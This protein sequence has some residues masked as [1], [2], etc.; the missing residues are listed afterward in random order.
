MPETTATSTD[1]CAADEGALEPFCTACGARASIFT[2]RGGKW[3]HYRG[4][5]DDLNVE[6]YDPGH[7]PV[8]GW[9]PSPGDV[10]V[11]R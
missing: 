3:L 7:A 8:I 9:R 5:A 11:A 10:F 1:F 6:P 4:G 2:G